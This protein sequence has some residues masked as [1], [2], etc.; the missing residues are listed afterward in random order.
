MLNS[1]SGE[2][3]LKAEPR[4]RSDDGKATECI[5]GKRA[6]DRFLA[7]DPFHSGTMLF[8]ETVG[9]VTSGPC[10]PAAKR[11]IRKAW[12]V[13]ATTPTPRNS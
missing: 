12:G 6:R 2:T 10:Q 8:P 1:S 5:Y 13:S 3:I 4:S 7:D 11:R 9:A